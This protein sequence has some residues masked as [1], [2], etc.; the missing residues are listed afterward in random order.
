MNTHFPQVERKSQ[1]ITH[2]LVI[3]TT[4]TMLMLT[5]GLSRQLEIR[6][7]ISSVSIQVAQPANNDALVAIRSSLPPIETPQS[8]STPEP[9]GSASLHPVPQV[10]RAPMPS[11]P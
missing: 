9:V 1:L 10:I 3:L 5:L 2:L 11:V 8:I 4:F 7:S 6:L